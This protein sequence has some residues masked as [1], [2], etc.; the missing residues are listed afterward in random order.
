MYCI[1]E[2]VKIALKSLEITYQ[3][4]SAKI[5]KDLVC[6]KHMSTFRDI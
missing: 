2:K 3:V 6:I 5:G 4:S 1:H